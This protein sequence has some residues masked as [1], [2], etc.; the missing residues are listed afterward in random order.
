MDDT[1]AQ[2]LKSLDVLVGAEDNSEIVSSIETLRSGLKALEDDLSKSE[3][4]HGLSDRTLKERESNLIDL[5][6]RVILPYSS[7]IG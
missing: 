5:Q 2:R 1:E 7:A 4:S 6:K 3:S